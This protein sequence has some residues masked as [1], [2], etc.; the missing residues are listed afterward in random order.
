MKLIFFILHSVLRFEAKLVLGPYMGS[1][2]Y[3]DENFI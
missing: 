3:I 2:E 1:V